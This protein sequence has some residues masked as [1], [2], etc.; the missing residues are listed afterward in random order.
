MIGSDM[1]TT[2]ILKPVDG[3]DGR[4][5]VSKRNYEQVPSRL[6]SVP[7]LPPQ[8]KTTWHEADGQLSGIMMSMSSPQKDVKD[9]AQHLWRGMRGHLPE[10]GQ[11]R[12]GEA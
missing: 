6:P 12:I 5:P 1:T 8:E 11:R 10:D 7:F 9:L 4:E 2:I 3:R